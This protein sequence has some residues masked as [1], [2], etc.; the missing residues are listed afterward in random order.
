M[1]HLHS[2]SPTY[3]SRPLIRVLESAC[4]ARSVLRWLTWFL[5]AASPVLGETPRIIPHHPPQAVYPGFGTAAGTVF[6]QRE[7]VPSA[8][9]YH[10][11]LD[12]DLRFSNC[13]ESP[14]YCCKDW[15]PITQI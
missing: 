9:R 11:R 3:Q 1:L 15:S 12:G 5:L 2:P 6:L 4:N 14:H 8:V 7:S 13:P 10:V